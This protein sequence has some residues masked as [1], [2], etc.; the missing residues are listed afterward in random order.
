MYKKRGLARGFVFGLTDVGKQ[1]KKKKKKVPGVKDIAGF[2]EGELGGLC[3]RWGWVSHL[4][5]SRQILGMCV[6]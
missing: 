3:E 5:G 6:T 1:P 2:F 4:Q